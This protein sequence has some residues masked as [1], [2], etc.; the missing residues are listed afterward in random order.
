M[1]LLAAGLQNRLRFLEQ[2]QQDYADRELR[3]SETITERLGDFARTLLESSQRLVGCTE[4]VDVNGFVSEVKIMLSQVEGVRLMLEVALAGGDL[5]PLQQVVFESLTPLQETLQFSSRQLI[6]NVEEEMFQPAETVGREVDAVLEAIGKLDFSSDSRQITSQPNLAAL[7][8]REFALEALEDGDAPGTQLLLRLARRLNAEQSPNFER[9]NQNYQTLK[10]VLEYLRDTCEVDE[11]DI[12]SDADFASLNDDDLPAPDELFEPI[13][14]PVIDHEK[15][16]AE[17]RNLIQA[18]TDIANPI[19][20]QIITHYIEAEKVNDIYSSL[21]DLV[22][23]L[24][25]ITSAG[26]FDAEW[27]NR[28]VEHDHASHDQLDTLLIDL[29][30]FVNTIR[31]VMDEWNR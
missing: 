16:T 13:E 19:S 6:M 7:I 8:A 23:A 31:K 2:K 24:S 17:L 15:L 10:Q 28:L 5:T 18:V 11:F 9:L 27:V 29:D 21:G 26:E 3:R 22:K 30:F 14:M 12:M 1:G 20:R 4:P 25:A